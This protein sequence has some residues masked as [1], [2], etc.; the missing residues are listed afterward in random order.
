MTMEWILFITVFQHDLFL[1]FPSLPS[2]D[3]NFVKFC[4]Y[5]ERNVFSI[6]YMGY[7]VVQ[8]VEALQCKPEGC[9][10]DCQ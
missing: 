7:A 9:G 1:V 8:S 10:I 2:T 4:T 5:E 6:C 3:T